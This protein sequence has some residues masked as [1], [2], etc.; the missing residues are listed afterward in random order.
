LWPECTQLAKK[1]S[2]KALAGLERFLVAAFQAYFSQEAIVLLVIRIP[3]ETKEAPILTAFAA[4]KN[5]R[6]KELAHCART[7]A[8]SGFP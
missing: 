7:M 8:Y 1:L 2:Q 5:Q 6:E 3:D 4:R